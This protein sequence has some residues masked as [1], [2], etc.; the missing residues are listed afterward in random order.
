MWFVSPST[1][2]NFTPFWKIEPDL[3]YNFDLIPLC[4][5]EIDSLVNFSVVKESVTTFVLFLLK[6]HLS[7]YLIFRFDLVDLSS[8]LSI[9]FGI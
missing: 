4:K 9:F 2:T 7:F 1:D 3:F 8:S 6:S 5:T